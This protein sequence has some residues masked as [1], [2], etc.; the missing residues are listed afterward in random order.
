MT[1]RHSAEAEEESLK[2]LEDFVAELSNA[3][4][5]L[6]GT[7]PNTLLDKYRF[8]SAKHLQRAL[9]AFVHLRRS[10]R[11]DGSKFLVR[12]ALEMAFRLEAARQHPDLFYRIAHSEHRQDRHLLQVAGQPQL[13]PQSDQNWER[14]KNAFVNE[15]PTVPVPNVEDRLLIEYIADKAALKS[16]YDAHYRIYSQYTHG[17]LR[18]STGTLDPATDREDNYIMTICALVALD[19]LRSF[20]AESQNRDRLEQRLSRAATARQRTN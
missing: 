4:D 8:W 7:K 18:A 5:S 20:G 17:A 15:F 12:P 3:L 9:N 14:F 19:N 6:G 2:L 10:G 11:L 1:A 16:Y 13:Q